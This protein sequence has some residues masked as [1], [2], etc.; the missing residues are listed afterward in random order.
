M[1]KFRFIVSTFAVLLLMSGCS[2]KENGGV[3]SEEET[4]VEELTETETEE[5][6]QTPEAEVTEVTNEPEVVA[7]EKTEVATQSA[8]NQAD[9]AKINK[10]LNEYKDWVDDLREGWY[11]GNEF[12][13]GAG[14]FFNEVL[15]GVSMAHNRLKALEG[16]M[17]PAQKAT[18]DKLNESIKE[19]L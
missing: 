15:S 2:N 8:S 10:L 12:T 11:D 6:V 17:T 7:P 5:T 13:P 9:E 16:Q 14:Q 1:K 3:T 18:F 4:A 19:V